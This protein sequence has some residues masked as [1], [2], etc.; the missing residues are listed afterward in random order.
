MNSRCTCLALSKKRRKRQQE[1]EEAKKRRKRQQEEEEDNGWCDCEID[2]APS[3]VES[4]KEEE[5]SMTEE[6]GEGANRRYE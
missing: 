6:N 1:E 4:D 3:V 5:I 2:Q